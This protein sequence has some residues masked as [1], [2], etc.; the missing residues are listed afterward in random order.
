MIS[1]EVNR[2]KREF[3]VKSLS[4]DVCV[5]S[6]VRRILL[7][8]KVRQIGLSHGRLISVPWIRDFGRGNLGVGVGLRG[9]V[10]G[11]IPPC[12]VVVI[13]SVSSHPTWW[14]HIQHI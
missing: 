10:S 9:P 4:N 13:L 1:N 6:H 7:A 5:V 11:F 12:G 2:P 3:T 8:S 14:Q